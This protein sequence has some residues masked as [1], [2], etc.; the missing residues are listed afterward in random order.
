MSFPTPVAA[1]QMDAKLAD[2]PA[3]IAQ[4]GDLAEQALKAGAKMVA[5]PEFFTTSIVFDERLY[6]C[7]LPPENPAVDMMTTLAHKYGATIGGSYLEKH[8]EDVFN[9]YVLVEPDGTTHRHDK[10]QP[11]MVENAFYAGGTDQGLAST[12][13]GNI[14]MAVCW[15]TIRTRTAPRLAGKVDVLMTGSHWWS[16]PMN[17]KL[18]RRTWKR[19]NAYNAEFMKRTPGIF[20]AMIGA[21]NMHAA[22]CGDVTGQYQLS[23]KWITAQAQLELMGETQI[24]DARGTILARRTRQEGPGFIQAEITLGAQTPAPTPEGFWVEKM[25]LMF[26]IFWHHQNFVASRSYQEAKR[27]GLLSTYDFSRNAPL[28]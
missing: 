7:S 3:N 9:T 10:D 27:K 15:E 21:P 14:G 22:H 13:A 1:V 20:A 6:S 11:T 12:K 28:E 16:P 19:M 5:L 23:S 2:I 24:T 26:R 25:P 4:A 17:W 8:E 18:G